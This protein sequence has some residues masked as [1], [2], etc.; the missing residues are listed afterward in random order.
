AALKAC[1]QIA[2]DV[3]HARIPG[4]AVPA[5]ACDAVAALDRAVHRA[6]ARVAFGAVPA[7]AV[8]ADVLGVAV[9]RIAAG[10]ALGADLAS[11]LKAGRRRLRAG[12]EVVALGGAIIARAAVVAGSA[13]V[14]RAARTGL[15]LPP[16]EVEVGLEI[17][18]ERGAALH[19]LG[20]DHPAHVDRVPRR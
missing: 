4:A 1:G 14:A 19:V 16:R 10:I 11:I 13:V 15:G 7:R 3:D 18:V 17:A 2:V 9:E 12:R 5:H 8:H 20:A 6:R